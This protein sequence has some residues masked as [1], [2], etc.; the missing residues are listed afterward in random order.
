M[1]FAHVCNGPLQHISWKHLKYA[2]HLKVRE[3]ARASSRQSVNRPCLRPAPAPAH[4]ISPSWLPRIPG[5]RCAIPQ[6]A[7]PP[8]QR[9]S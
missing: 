9:R 3:S 2:S 7:R 1:I 8:L 6:P 4:T 5:R